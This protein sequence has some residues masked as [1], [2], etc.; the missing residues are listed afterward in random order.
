MTAERSSQ[1]LRKLASNLKVLL[2]DVDGV[3]TDGGI[4]LLED[5]GEAK[6][7]HVQDGM[8]VNIA[9]AAG[10]KV[11]IVTSRSSNI[12]KRRAGELGIDMVFQGVRRKVDVLEVLRDEFAAVPTEVSFIGDDIQDVAIMRAVGIPI[13][14]QNAVQC[15]KD[16]SVY[17]TRAKG[18]HGAVRE[19]VDWVLETRGDQDKVYE[20]II[21]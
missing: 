17:V 16:S 8:A 2:L 11:G 10:L 5:G 3:L 13:A 18:G 15:V 6:R 19:A 12:V 9:R 21:G 7:F 14:V 20:S 1:E 4:V